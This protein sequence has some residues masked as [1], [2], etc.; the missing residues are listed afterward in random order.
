MTL[1]D[2]VNEESPENP[3]FHKDRTQFSNSSSNDMRMSTMKN[4]FTYN[5]DYK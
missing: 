3:I 4:A 1:V 5:F 2:K